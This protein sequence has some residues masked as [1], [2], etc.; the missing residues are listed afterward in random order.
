MNTWRKQR[1]SSGRW[2]GGKEVER[3]DKYPVPNCWWSYSKILS[4]TTITIFKHTIRS[5]AFWFRDHENRW[6]GKWLRIFW[7]ICHHSSYQSTFSPFDVPGGCLCIEPT[8]VRV[9][10][11]FGG[12]M[13]CLV[14]SLSLPA[15]FFV[16]LAEIW[17]PTSTNQHPI[18]FMYVFHCFPLLCVRVS[19]A[20]KD[21]NNEIKLLMYR[22]QELSSHCCSKASKLL[23]SLT[24]WFWQELS[25]RYAPLKGDVSWCMMAWIS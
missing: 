11:P 7:D 25:S 22:L 8:A 10:R 13:I 14:V 5:V 4:Q 9:G 3:L 21:R 2:E 20:W 18:P 19:K 12:A 1:R 24:F 16:W 15:K 17:N 23:Q 6:C